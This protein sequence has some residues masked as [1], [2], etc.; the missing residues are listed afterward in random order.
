MRTWDLVG[1]AIW[2]YKIVIRTIF[3]V[4]RTIYI[5]WSSKSCLDFRYSSQC[6]R[7]DRGELSHFLFEDFS[8]FRVW[9]LWRLRYAKISSEL[10]A[11]IEQYQITFERNTMVV[12]KHKEMSPVKTCPGYGVSC[13]TTLYRIKSDIQTQLNDNISLIYTERNGSYLIQPGRS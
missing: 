9:F 4:I 3:M 11:T 10:L 13:H 1:T 7:V 12:N 2:Q 6:N 8:I 5:L